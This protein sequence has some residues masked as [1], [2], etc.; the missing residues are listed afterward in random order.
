MKRLSLV[1]PLVA[2][3]ALC[4]WGVEVN[5]S[6]A[7]GAFTTIQAAVDSGATT[8]TI[9]DSGTYDE[10]VRIGTTA[11][12]GTPI[13][14]TSTKTGTERPVLQSTTPS[15]VYV[16]VRNDVNRATLG[17][18]SDGCMISNL[19]VEGNPMFQDGGGGQNGQGALFVMADN[20]TF[21][22]CLFRPMPNDGSS[23][24]LRIKFPNSLIFVAMEG[25]PSGNIATSNGKLSDGLLFRNCEMSAI[26]KN[27]N[28]EPDVDGIDRG[29]L[30]SGTNS[31]A[32]SLARCDHYTEANQNC[33]VTF[34]GCLLHFCFDAGFFP[35]NRDK[36]DR[37]NLGSVTWIARNCTFDGFGKFAFRGRGAN[38]IA[39]CC[40][41]TRTN[42][43][44]N[45]DGENSAV[46]I[47]GQ[48]GRNNVTATVSNCLFVNCGG[49]WTQKSYHGGCNNHNAGLMTVDHCTFVACMNGIGVGSDGAA[50]SATQVA[51]SNCLFH[52]IGYNT[53]GAVDGFGALITQDH[54]DNVS[55]GIYPA[56]DF[57]QDQGVGNY[58]WPAVFSHI[59]DNGSTI[60]IENCL[61]GEIASEDTRT[62]ADALAAGDVMGARLAAGFTEE[63]ETIIGINNV[64]RATPIFTNTDLTAERPFELASNSPG[65]GLGRDYSVCTSVN[66]W[67][68]F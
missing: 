5:K 2:A 29:F 45:G 11:G 35:S 41:F 24:D 58:K 7:N 6:G 67:C 46:A 28:S 18:L 59:N 51:V 54:P 39:E 56:W 60:T 68:L 15:P 38:V 31:T 20:V 40:T 32:D 14:L 8:I 17:V 33:T 1:L 47:Q 63:G 52:Q 10:N 65:Q 27:A 42:Q 19:I 49:A 43:N 37:L 34:E 53:T 36:G 3:V 26:H 50:T 62:W 55:P 64:S 4:G 22:N 48:D 61:V 66:D 57:L 25:N 21:E 9:T 30:A 23:T 13:T 16:S 12:R 44:H